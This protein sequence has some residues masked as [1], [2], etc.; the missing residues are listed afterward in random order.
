M[1][2]SP[3]PQKHINLLMLL[4]SLLK[5]ST[6]EGYNETEMLLFGHFPKVHEPLQIYRFVGCVAKTIKGGFCSFPGPP[7]SI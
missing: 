6:Y 3:G 4:Q 5:N 2:S 7:I 1:N